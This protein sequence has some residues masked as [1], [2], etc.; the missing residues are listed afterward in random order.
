MQFHKL[1]LCCLISGIFFQALPM[2]TK[3]EIFQ[4]LDKG[5]GQV[6]ELKNF[7]KNNDKAILETTY[8]DETPLF[9]SLKNKKDSFSEIL[10]KAG[11]DVNW[12]DKFG[13]NSLLHAVQY[14]GTDESFQ[15]LDMLI[16]QGASTIKKKQ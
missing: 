13:N 5:E 10:I 1:I 2:S 8:N 3:P 6:D 4:L 7:L 9:Y 15:I 11:A 16:Q 14:L 12:V